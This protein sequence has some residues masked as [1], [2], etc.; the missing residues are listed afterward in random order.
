MYYVYAVE[1]EP[2]QAVVLHAKLQTEKGMLRHLM[3][4]RSTVKA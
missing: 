3:V 4:K 2:T 1:I